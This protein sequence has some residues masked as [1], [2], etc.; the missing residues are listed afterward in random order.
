MIREITN[1]ENLDVIISSNGV[2]IHMIV[3]IN[4]EMIVAKAPMLEYF[5]QKN[6]SSIT[7]ENVFPTPPHAQLIIN[8]TRDSVVRAITNPNKDAKTTVI[9]EYLNNFLS[10]NFIPNVPRIKSS[11]IELTT[12]INWES[13]VVIIAAII[14]DNKIPASHAG[15]KSNT[16]YGS[17]NS[18][19]STTFEPYK[20]NP[21]NPTKKAPVKETVDQKSTVNVPVFNSLLFLNAIN[22]VLNCGCPPK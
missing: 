11:L 1:V 19:S 6:A 5:F 18:T 2:L 20:V 7:T 16:I 21:V 8:N 17:I 9:F 15:V 3:L 14:P 22:L 10:L 12:T 4:P 13:P